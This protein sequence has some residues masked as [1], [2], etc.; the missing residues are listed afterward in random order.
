MNFQK[1]KDIGLL[2]CLCGIF[3]SVADIGSLLR[4]FGFYG[5]F[6]GVLFC[7]IGI[8]NRKS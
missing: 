7:V 1:V 4:A 5:F 3:L 2:L 6:V 8:V